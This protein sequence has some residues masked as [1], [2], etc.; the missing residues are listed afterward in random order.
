LRGDCKLIKPRR[1]LTKFPRSVV[2]VNGVLQALPEGVSD[3]EEL[4]REIGFAVGG[5]HQFLQVITTG[6]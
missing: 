5:E 6:W 3:W 1:F 2:W 4:D